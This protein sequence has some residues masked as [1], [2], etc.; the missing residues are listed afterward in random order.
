MERRAGV[1]SLTEN[2]GVL[3]PSAYIAGKTKPYVPYVTGNTKTYVARNKIVVELPSTSTVDGKKEEGP[4]TK[5]R[6]R[7]NMPVARC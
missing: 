6:D 4:V 5:V 2:A 7:R 3:V 1:K